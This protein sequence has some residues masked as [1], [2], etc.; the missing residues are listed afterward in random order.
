MTDMAELRELDY[1]KITRGDQERKLKQEKR[2]VQCALKLAKLLDT[3]IQDSSIEKT[4]FKTMLEA[5]AKDLSSTSFGSALIGVLAYVYVEQASN[6]LGFKNSFASGI[7]INSFTQTAHIFSNKVKILG[8]A[9]KVLQVSRKDQ[10]KV[11]D[12]NK[13][14]ISKE[15]VGG[16][17]ETLW[18]YTVVDVEFTLRHVCLKVL[19]DCSVSRESRIERAE[20]LLLV[21]QK[22]QQFAQTAE[23]GLNEFGNQFASSLAQESQN[24]K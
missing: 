17:M 9:L 12:G 14:E 10:L 16:I 24:M 15:T 22:F 4:G 8:S 19:K 20:A 18:N 2:E 23:A 5:E 3:Y 11:A 6:Y 7:G 21:G 13:P 1:D